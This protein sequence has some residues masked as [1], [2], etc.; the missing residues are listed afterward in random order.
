MHPLSTGLCLVAVSWIV[1]PQP[2][3]AQSPL[4]WGPRAWCTESHIGGPFPDCSYYTLE[5]CRETTSFGTG[6]HCI[7]NPFYRP[8]PKQPAPRRKHR[9]PS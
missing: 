8:E 9:R 4:P 2:S 7:A 5:Q 6:L 3:G 1:A